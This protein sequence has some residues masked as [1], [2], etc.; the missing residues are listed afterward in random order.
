MATPTPAANPAENELTDVQK[1]IMDRAKNQNHNRAVQIHGLGNYAGSGGPNGFMH[2]VAQHNASQAKDMAE[3][4]MAVWGAEHSNRVLQA[5][6]QEQR[7]H[8]AN[9]QAMQTQAE[10]AKQNAAMQMHRQS[11]DSKNQRNAALLGAAGL[12]STT[13]SGGGQNGF[14][15]FRNGLLQ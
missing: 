6:E 5:R 10:M 8:E 1:K 4:A 14:Q 11:L 7:N 9:L 15:F 2:P 3:T 13:V 12:G